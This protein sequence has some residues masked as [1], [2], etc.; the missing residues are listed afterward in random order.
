MCGFIAIL[1]TSAYS[2]KMKSRG[3]FI[4]AGC[5]LAIAGYIML[6]VAKTPGVKYGGTFLVATGIY[7]GTPMSAFPALVAH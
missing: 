4:I 3:P 7:P 5:V 1:A 2:D 6:L